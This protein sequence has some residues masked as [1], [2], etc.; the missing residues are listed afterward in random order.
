[1]SVRII[2]D[3]DNS[4]IYDSVTMTAFGPVF[5]RDED[6]NDFLEWLPKDARSY[7]ANELWNLYGDWIKQRDNEAYDTNTKW[8]TT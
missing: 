6:P 2:T 3:G 1:M 5:G 7:S 4:V 8:Q